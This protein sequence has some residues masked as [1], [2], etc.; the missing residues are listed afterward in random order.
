MNKF[1]ECGKRRDHIIQT[2]LCLLGKTKS[3]RGEE[4]TMV[5]AIDRQVMDSK[6]HLMSPNLEFILSHQ[7]TWIA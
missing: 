7:V 2:S 6:I 5:I 3:R 4:Q 1:A